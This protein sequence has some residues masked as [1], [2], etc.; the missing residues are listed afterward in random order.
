MTTITAKA[1]TWTE[2]AKAWIDSLETNPRV[3]DLVA[4]SAL[5]GCSIIGF[6]TFILAIWA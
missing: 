1:A 4:W 2:A 3:Q 6:L 5:A